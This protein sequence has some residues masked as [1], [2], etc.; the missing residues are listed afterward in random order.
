MDG[1]INSFDSVL[2]PKLEVFLE[3]VTGP[4]QAFAAVIAIIYVGY[5]VMLYMSNPQENLDP[6]VLIKPILVLAAVGLYVELTDILVFKPMGLLADLIA[7]T[8]KQISGFSGVGFDKAFR[9]GITHVQTEGGEGAGVY[10]VIQIN[11]ALETL[12]LVIYFIASVSGFYII[13]RQFMTKYIY[14]LL[15]IF[16]LP[17]SLIIGNQRALSNWFFGFVSV[18]LWTPILNIIKMI[19]IILPVKEQTFG[20]VLLSVALQVVLIFTILKIPRLANILVTQGSEMGKGIGSQL[21]GGMGSTAL[22]LTKGAASGALKG[23]GWVV[24]QPFKRSRK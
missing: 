17:F 21:R 23:V 18:L 19:I 12:H 4:L 14:Y 20:N 1:V 15:G 6:Y 7:E 10:D 22:G 16:V 11:P 8:T 3:T 9:D 2:R 5:K 13:F 24:K